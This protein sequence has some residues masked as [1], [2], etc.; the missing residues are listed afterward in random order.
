MNGILQQLSDEEGQLLEDSEELLTAAENFVEAVRRSMRL[1]RREQMARRLELSLRKAFHEQERLFMAGFRK[2]LRR[3]FSEDFEGQ[4]A[5]Q[6]AP[7]NESISASD[8]LAV[9]IV[10]SQKTV[11][12]FARPIDQA[13]QA[14]FESGALAMIGDVGIEL[15]FNLSNPRAE[16]Y[17]A[18]YGARL[19]ANID[20]TTREYLQTVITQAVDEGWSYD[21]TAQAIANRYEEFAVGRPQEHIDSRAHGI[22]VTEIGNAYAEGNLAVAQELQAAGIRMEKKW[23]TVGDDRVNLEICKPNEQQ[24]WIPLDQ[25]FQSGHLRPLGHP[26]CRC[27]LLTRRKPD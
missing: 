8:W 19:V 10:V 22:A 17:L 12:L 27:D 4:A 2:H 16:A 1:R 18:D 9:W 6:Q 11:E 25:P 26:Y 3:F 24:S 7:L 20:E 14:A 5:F 13:V 23:D 15:S 21:Q